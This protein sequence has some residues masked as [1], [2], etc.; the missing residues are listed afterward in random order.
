[1]TPLDNTPASLI[2]VCSGITVNANDG[3]PE[4]VCNDC[5]EALHSYKTH[6][7]R[8]EGNLPF[9]CN[10]CEKKFRSSHNLN[11][12]VRNFHLCIKPYSCSFCDK[13]FGFQ[14]NKK[15]H[16]YSH[17]GNYPFACS[18]CPRKFSRKKIHLRHM[19]NFLR[20]QPKQVLRTE[21]KPVNNGNDK[22]GTRKKSVRKPVDGCEPSGS[23]FR[24]LFCNNLFMSRAGV[25][26]HISNM[27]YKIKPFCCE[28][29]GFRFHTK[30]AL[31]LHLDRHAVL[32]AQ[33]D[34]NMKMHPWANLLE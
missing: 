4:W 30:H 8:H 14:S 34:L 24:C 7:D 16:E 13:K 9:S 32:K 31:K 25:K 11:R 29:C 18:Y 21:P 3:L 26:I 19:E 1:M 28:V 23:K 27:H 10:A 2:T 6:L 12:H 5:L 17:T 20:T 33:N 15:Q 22:K